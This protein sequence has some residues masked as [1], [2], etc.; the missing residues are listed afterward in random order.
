MGH[1]DHPM[2]AGP[3]AHHGLP[4]RHGPGLAD[5]VLPDVMGSVVEFGSA[6]GQHVPHISGDTLMVDDLAE[7]PR[8]HPRVDVAVF[9]LGGTRVLGVLVT[10]DAQQGVEAV[11]LID[12]GTSIPV[13][14]DDYD[15]SPPRSSTSSTRWTVPA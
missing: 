6:D 14:H 9:H 8:R 4:G 10:M 15:G 13:H 2:C 12:A 11:R 3:R 7:N 1:R 5:L